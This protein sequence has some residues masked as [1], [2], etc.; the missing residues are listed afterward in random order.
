MDFRGKSA[1]EKQIIIFSFYRDAE[2]RG[3]NFPQ[4]CNRINP[5]AYI[6]TISRA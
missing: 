4:Y 3:A 2:L 6:V 1:V 5:A